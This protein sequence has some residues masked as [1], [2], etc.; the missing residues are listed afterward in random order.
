MIFTTPSGKREVVS[1]LRWNVA[2]TNPEVMTYKGGSA[3][4][5]QFLIT[6]QSPS[7][8]CRAS[9]NSREVRTGNIKNT[10]KGFYSVIANKSP[11]FDTSLDSNLNQIGGIQND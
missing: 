9:L 3:V 5:K 10:S 7:F 2:K 8:G 6:K 4:R 1:T 11:L